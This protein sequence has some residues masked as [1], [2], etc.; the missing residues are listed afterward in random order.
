MSHNWFEITQFPNRIF[1]IREPG[2]GPLHSSHSW[3]IVGNDK[4]LLID[5]CVGIVPLSPFVRSL[6]SRPVICLLSH[7]HYDHIGG[8]YEFMDRRMHPAEMD[9]LENPTPELTF[10]GGWLNIDSFNFLP[11]PNYDFSNYAIKPAPPTGLLYDGDEIDLGG[12]ILQILHV[13]GHSPGLIAVYDPE[14]GALFSSDALYQGKMFFDL[15]GSDKVA[16]RQSIRRLIN[17]GA[18]IL[19]P[20]HYDILQDDAIVATAKSQL[21]LLNG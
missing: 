21:A 9:I 2:L 5:T 18:R 1:R 3:L 14:I 11:T 13:P 12:R 8:A 17:L 7:S 4:A 16:A 15:K 6:T 19:Y 20:G 10:W